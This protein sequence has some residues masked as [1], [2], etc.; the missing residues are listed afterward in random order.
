[1]FFLLLLTSVLHTVATV[2]VLTRAVLAGGAVVVG[3]VAGTRQRFGS[4]EPPVD[5]A[6]HGTSRE[7]KGRRVDHGVGGLVKR[8]GVV[9]AVHRFHVERFRR[10]LKRGRVRHFL[11]HTQQNKNGLCTN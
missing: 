7:R 11:I 9:K 4:A 8:L 2:G 5:R 1:M 6:G 3:V 10:G